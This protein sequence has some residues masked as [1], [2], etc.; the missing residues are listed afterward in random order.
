MTL[1]AFKRAI[2][3]DSAFAPAYLHTVGLSMLLGDTAAAQ[4]CATAFL[5]LKPAEE[6]AKPIRVTN[7]I[8]RAGVNSPAIQ[9]L[10]DTLN[11]HAL[12]RTWLQ[13]SYTTD[14]DE[15]LIELARRLATRPVHADIWFRDSSVRQLILG[16]SLAYRGHLGEAAKVLG[17]LREFPETPLFVELALAEAIDQDSVSRIFNQR[18]NRTSFWPIGGLRFAPVFWTARGDSSSLKL[19]LDRMDWRRRSPKPPPF[20]ITNPYW[21]QAGEAYLTLLRGDTTAALE[22][23]A[24]LPAREGVVWFEMFTE[25]RLR[26]LRGDTSQAL[27]ILDREYPAPRMLPSRA[28]W[29][30]ERARLA[31]KLGQGDKALTWYSF[32]ANV[33]RHADPELQAYATDARAGLQR[34]G[35][36]RSV[37]HFRDACSP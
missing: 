4:T 2:R 31:E 28:L 5:S 10:L 7:A 25:A 17:G 6:V 15:T 34:L 37:S 27:A 30:L 16:M 21:I 32:V 8:L 13:F 9:Q 26:T 20:A 22:R 14:P 18:L 12:G 33:W 29:A 3:L 11:G 23:F 35:D 24:R 1:D 36:K 19:Y